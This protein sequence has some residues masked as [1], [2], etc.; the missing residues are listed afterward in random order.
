TLSDHVKAR[1]RLDPREAAE[2]CRQAALGLAAAHAAGLIHRDVKPANV[3]LESLPGDGPA[4][5]RARLLDFGLVR[6]KEG[7]R[8][9]TREGTVAGTPEYMSPEQ[10]REPARI[11]ER[12][13][14]YNL[15]AT[16]YEALTGEA[17]F[18]GEVLRVLEQV[19]HDDPAPPRR[20]SDRIPRD[21]ET[22]C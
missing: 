1:G 13:D 10:L 5:Y 7:P 19:L 14:V 21:L 20:L 15:G 8:G 11:D 2:L 16:L 22:V 6:L 3:I 9:L 12:S 4:R 17:P 18:R